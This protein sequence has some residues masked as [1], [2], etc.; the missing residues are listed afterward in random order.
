MTDFK[1]VD[2]GTVLGFTPLTDEAQEFLDEQVHIED[3]Q[4]VGKQFY[5]DHRP[6]QHLIDGIVSAGLSV[7]G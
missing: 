7:G 5:V 6:A 1:A 3:W 2:H 4:W